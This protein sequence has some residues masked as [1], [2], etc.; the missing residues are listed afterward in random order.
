MIK[1]KGLADDI[2]STLYMYI[3]HDHMK[4]QLAYNMVY[5]CSPFHQEYIIKEGKRVSNAIYL[6]C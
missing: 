2:V 5:T 1:L 3:S 6:A 4:M